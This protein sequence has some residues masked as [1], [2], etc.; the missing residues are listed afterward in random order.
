MTVIE[1]R[2]NYYITHPE[3]YKLLKI[4]TSSRGN[5]YDQMVINEVEKQKKYVKT[6]SRKAI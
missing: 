5:R 4:M 3:D 1:K 6:Y 2:V